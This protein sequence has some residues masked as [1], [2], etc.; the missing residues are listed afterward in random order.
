MRCLRAPI[1]VFCVKKCSLHKTVQIKICIYY[2]SSTYG[3]MNQTAPIQTTL[4]H[5]HTQHYT[6]ATLH[7]HQHATTNRTTDK[8]PKAQTQRHQQLAHTSSVTL[9]NLTPHYKRQNPRLQADH[10]YLFS[11]DGLGN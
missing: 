4:A 6:H 11:T 8:T 10:H 3:C 9:H 7:I 1:A 5:T 2:N